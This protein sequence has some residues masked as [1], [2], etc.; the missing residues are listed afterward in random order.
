MEKLPLISIVTPV[1]NVEKFLPQCIDSILAQTFTDWELI[2]VDD[3]S[4]DGSAGICDSY[5]AKD[6]RIR[7]VHKENSGQADSRNLGMSMARADLLG[8]V[9]S[10]DWI[11]PGMYEVLYGAL[12]E[13]GADISICGH[14]T[15]YADRERKSCESGGTVAL[16]G[17][18]ALSH[19]IDDDVIKSYLWDKL[20]RKEVITE[21]LPKSYYYEDYSTLF[22]WFT[23]VDKVVLC[24]IPLYHY[25]Q[26]AGSTDHDCDPHKRYH[27]FLA[28]QERLKFLRAK[29][30]LPERRRE[31]EVKFVTCGIQ[32]IK[33]MARQSGHGKQEME[34]ASKIRARIIPYLPIS[35]GELG[36]RKYV[37]LLMLRHSIR[38]Y[39]RMM[40]IERHIV[41]DRR[42]KNGVFYG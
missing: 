34:Y 20:F 28:E 3:G 38:L 7:V 35:I 17:A 19:I 26:R 13:N 6:S 8:F 21:Q 31:F 10:D 2:L 41:F 22:K 15:S 36:F 1:Y 16:T 27:F 12:T 37:R 5:A 39:L 24:Q 42:L 9:D 25:R 29:R 40:C 33:E 11:D 18:E 30:L 4:T 14:Y 23:N 32:A